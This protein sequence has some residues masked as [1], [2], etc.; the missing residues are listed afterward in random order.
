MNNVLMDSLV[1]FTFQPDI[2]RANQVLAV[3]ILASGLAHAESDSDPAALKQGHKTRPS[4]WCF[5]GPSSATT[6][7]TARLLSYLSNSAHNTQP[8]RPPT[9]NWR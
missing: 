9:M 5:R 7:G 2:G 8:T 6:G 4:K 1:G 3:L